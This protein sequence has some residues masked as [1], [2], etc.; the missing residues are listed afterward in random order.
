MNTYFT[1]LVTTAYRPFI[2]RSTAKENLNMDHVVLLDVYGV[3]IVCTGEDEI[4]R[5]KFMLFQVDRT[6]VILIGLIPSPERESKVKT[7][8]CHCSGD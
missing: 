3:E 2:V 5:L 7:Q 4:A 1:D 6:S 8:I